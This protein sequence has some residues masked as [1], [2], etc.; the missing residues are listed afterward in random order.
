MSRATAWLSLDKIEGGGGIIT[1]NITFLRRKRVKN[2]VYF[3]MHL[4]K[5]S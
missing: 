3:W 2:K 1:A 4:Y 5:G